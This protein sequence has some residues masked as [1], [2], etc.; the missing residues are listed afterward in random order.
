MSYY[1]ALIEDVGPD[2]AVGVWFPDIPGCFSA[3]DS[4]EEAMLNAEE[5]LRAF[6]EAGGKLTNP[7][8][9]SELRADP[10]VAEDI[11]KHIVALVQFKHP[12]RPAAE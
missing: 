12:L 9:L 1:I 2:T 8:S 10:E 3:S 6:A 11:K 5:A 4:I 7:R